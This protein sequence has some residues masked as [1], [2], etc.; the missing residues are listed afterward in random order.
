MSLARRMEHEITAIA[1][2]DA[3]RL[4]ISY[5]PRFESALFDMVNELDQPPPQVSIEV[6]IVEVTIDDSLELGVEFAFQD[7][8]FTKAGPSDTTT[9]DFVGG[10]DIGAAGTGLGGFSFT[11]TGADFNFLFRTLQNEG[12]LRVLSRP[13]IVAM[14]NQPA[15]IEIIDRVPIVTTAVTGTGIV[16]SNVSYEEVG[17][18]LEVT[19]QINPDG[20]V[21][22]QILQEVSD[23]SSAA[24]GGGTQPQFFSREAETTITVRDNETVVL[25][26]LIT[27]RSDAREQKVPILGDIPLLG[28]LFRYETDMNSR[29]ELLIILTPRV[30]RTVEDYRELSIEARDATG[31]IPDEFLTNPLMHKLRVSPEDLLPDDGG[32]TIGPFPTEAGPT[33]VPADEGDVYGPLRRHGDSG[34]RKQGVK[35]EPASYDVPLTRR[36]SP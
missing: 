14:D 31:M 5:D 21:R 27:S 36:S 17:I 2:V 19:P 6:L 12:S 3:N 35:A 30:I 29:T 20:F 11:V 33:D 4:I 34:K 7:L 8:Q 26:G 23:V 22:M 9:F 25:G 10:T 16:Q 13:Q 28:M 18:K 15:R 1:N 32:K 24:V